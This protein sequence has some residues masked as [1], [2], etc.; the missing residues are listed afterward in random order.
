LLFGGMATGASRLSP[1]P[2]IGNQC[3]RPH[4]SNQRSTDHICD[5]SISFFKLNFFFSFGFSVLSGSG[6]VLGGFGLRPSFRASSFA[7][8]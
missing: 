1:G 5:H 7:I 3:E 4:A 2:H 8:R 6:G